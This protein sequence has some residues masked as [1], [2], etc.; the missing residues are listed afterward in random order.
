MVG[1]GPASVFRVS[2]RETLGEEESESRSRVVESL[3]TDEPNIPDSESEHEPPRRVSFT[4]R[5]T[6][7]QWLSVVGKLQVGLGFLAVF[8]GFVAAANF[9]P[10]YALVGCLWGVGLGLSGLTTQGFA[11]IVE[12]ASRELHRMDRE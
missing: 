2:T 4:F 7:G 5:S 6:V 1:R 3:M 10:P 11:A 12:Y 9:R 8:L